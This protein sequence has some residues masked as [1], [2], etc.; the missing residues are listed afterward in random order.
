MYEKLKTKIEK[1]AEDYTDLLIKRI[2]T[3]NKELDSGIL[4]AP[5][6]E[7]FIKVDE[8]MRMVMYMANTLERIDRPNRGN[9]TDGL[10]D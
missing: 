6:A 8:A 2:E 10:N 3:A 5:A 1:A 9:E 7:P 4:S